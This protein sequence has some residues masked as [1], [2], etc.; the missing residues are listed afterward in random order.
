M[1]RLFQDG[2]EFNSVT[3]NPAN[4]ETISGSPTI[5]TTTVRSGTYAARISSLVSGTPKGFIK[6]WSGTTANGPFFGRTYIY[7]HARPSASNHIIS[8]NSASGTAGTSERGKITLESNGTLVLREASGTA[9]GSPSSA[10]SLDTWYCVELKMD[11]T[12]ANGSQILEARLAPDDGSTPTIF[13]TSSALTI[14]G[15]AFALSV[16]GNL[17]L[18]AQTT[19]DWFFDD[20]A[21]NDNTGSFQTSY[22]GQGKIIQLRPSATGD[23]NTL[24][25][26]TGG[27]AG[28]ANNF[29]RVDEVTP[30]D[31]T[32][33]NGS[34]ILN[35]EDMYN[36]DNSGI[37]SGDMVNVVSVGARFRNNTA[38]ATT[39]MNLQLEKTSGGTRTTSANIIPNTTSWN[40]N[41]AASP[42]VY[43]ITTYQDPDGSAWTQ[44]TLDSMQIGM[45][46]GVGSANRIDLTSIWAS[47]DYTA[48]TGS[49]TQQTVTGVS[50]IQKAVSQTIQGVSR[51]TISSIRTITGVARI[52]KLTSQ[53]IPGKANIVVGVNRTITGVSRITI[54]TSQTKT[55]KASILRTVLQTI[56]GLARLT[57]SATQNTTG[58][59]RITVSAPQI[60]QGKASILKTVART[61]TGLARLTKNASQTI[62]GR[63]RITK[64]VSQTILGLARI[65]AVT[66]RTVAGNARITIATART[67]TGVS[68]VTKSVSKTVTGVANIVSGG[69]T[70]TTKTIIGVARIASTTT[71]TITGLAR[72]QKTIAQT[73]TG[74]ARITAVVTRAVTGLARITKSAS[75]TVT[76]VA[77]VSISST[78]TI[79]GHS[80]ITVIVSRTITGIAKVASLST[81]NVTGKASLTIP[82]VKPI[83]G[84]ATI[85]RTHSNVK[86]IAFIEGYTNRPGVPEVGGPLAQIPQI[87]AQPSSRDFQWV[88]TSIPA[89]QALFDDPVALFDDDQVL[90]GRFIDYSRAPQNAETKTVPIRIVIE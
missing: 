13:A 66:A 38:S 14:P 28:G 44:T 49:T 8:F 33:F 65:T 55:G 80:R 61:I 54:S 73:Q 72:I 42:R 16:G 68:R 47:V 29:T 36:L 63:S 17:D 23:T 9:V 50:R 43:P 48:S 4:W 57:K 24:S 84:T 60:V 10:L 11:R 70:T 67:I 30:D 56:P 27:T 90:F 2:F 69:I 75:R 59:S 32:T 39:R 40:T 25:T 82:S 86:P 77:R 89:Q 81:R 71:R 35:E 3:N 18:E 6:K 88:D 62:L 7:V 85:V 41:D 15:A 45:K 74:K 78:R 79:T 26:Q 53:T 19:G 51:I 76:G 46:I 58:K 12:P 5:S 20:I 31:A 34:N 87:I 52:T 22:P 1:A 83:T 37:G 64:A 21:V